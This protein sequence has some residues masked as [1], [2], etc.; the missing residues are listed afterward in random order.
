MNR[1][2]QFSEDLALFKRYAQQPNVCLRNR[3]VQLNLG[4]VRKVAYQMSRTCAETYEDLEQVAVFGLIRAV[5]RFNADRGVAFSSFA[6]PYI[7][8]EILHYLRDR[9]SMIKI[10]RVWQELH[11]KGQ[12][13][14]RKL[15]TD[16]G[17]SPQDHELAAALGVSTKDWQDCELAWKN[18]LL[19][20]LDV[21]LGNNADDTVTLGETL[22]DNHNLE[23]QQREEI[24]LQLQDVFVHLEKRTK[25]AIQLVCLEELPRTEA[26]K[27][28]GISPMTVSRHLKKGMQQMNQLLEP[29]AA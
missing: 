23:Q 26:A 7:R 28:I 25:D 19:I 24:K 5:E 6:M 17:R 4:L 15:R 8:G 14:R 3:L 20:S 29:Q 11:S 1:R 13:L 2:S 27:R 9:G 10:P 12:K 22:P 21:T 18:R 16:L